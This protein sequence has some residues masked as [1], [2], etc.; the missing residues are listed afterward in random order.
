M[1][2]IKWNLYNHKRTENTQKN[3][4]KYQRALVVRQHRNPIL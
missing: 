2:V 4:A 3:S 1:L